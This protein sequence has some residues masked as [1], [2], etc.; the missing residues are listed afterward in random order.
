MR[1]SGWSL[2]NF[3]FGT[4]TDGM[5]RGSQVLTVSGSFTNSHSMYICGEPTMCQVLLCMLGKGMGA[6][7]NRTEDVLSL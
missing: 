7:E 5:V 3:V 2:N 6:A 1:G 4:C